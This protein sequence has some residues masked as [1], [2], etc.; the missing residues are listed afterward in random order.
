[1]LTPTPTQQEE[2]RVLLDRIEVTAMTPSVVSDA[3]VLVLSVI[4]NDKHDVA[5]D[6]CLSCGCNAYDLCS[7]LGCLHHPPL[8]EGGDDGIS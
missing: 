2:A 1:M 7:R 6:T 8:L 4:A 3:L 5:G